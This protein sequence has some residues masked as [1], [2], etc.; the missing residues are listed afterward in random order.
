MSAALEIAVAGDAD[1]A[2]WADYVAAN[3][4]ATLFHDWRWGEAVKAAY[5]RQPLNLLARR[6]GKVV[7]LLPLIDVRSI[8][9][10]RSLIS[11]AFSI[12]GGVL[13]DDPEALE[14][15]AARALALGRE[16]RVTYVELRGGEA[17]GGAW[18]EKTG[19]YATFSKTLPARDEDILPAIPKN[20]RAEI[21]KAM[22]I[23]SDGHCHIKL[24]GSPQE[25]H[26]LYAEA[27]RHLGTPVFPVTFVEALAE[28]FGDEMEIALVDHQG[29]NV[30]TL[31]SFW[32][33]DRVMPYYIGGTEA[34][35]GIR[36]YDYLYYNL[37]RRAV[38]RG[39]KTYDFGRSKIGSTQFNTKTHW[40]FEPQPIVY[41]VALVTAKELPNVNPTN[42]KFA[43][44]SAIWKKLPTPL[45]NVVG[46]MLAR[47]LA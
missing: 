11:T 24:G 28:R 32:R 43:A 44:V 27:V 15:L 30:A 19:L 26:R 42:P 46:P 31:L 33:R 5:G 16:R 6:G 41:H 8:F 7:G 20:R 38:A 14:A 4:R 12:G 35:R 29:A 39:V 22:R 13:A 10:G 21:K 23:E 34:A 45:A 47:H 2:A 37:M 3:N 18:S 1:K 17:P 40:G 25:F 9:F 36:A